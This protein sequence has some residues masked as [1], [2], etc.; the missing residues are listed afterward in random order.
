MKRPA[1]KHNKLSISDFCIIIIIMLL[2]LLLLLL[3]A[4]LIYIRIMQNYVAIIFT[5]NNLHGK[6]EIKA[7]S[8]KLLSIS[9]F[10]SC[11]SYVLLYFCC[12]VFISNFFLY[13]TCITYCVSTIQL[14][15]HITVL[16][17]IVTPVIS[18]F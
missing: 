8:T 16:Q 18:S 3:F 2:L 15:P 12:I 17:C 6:F 14:L 11:K 9:F 10:F 5:T 7:A 4:V 13:H 1:L